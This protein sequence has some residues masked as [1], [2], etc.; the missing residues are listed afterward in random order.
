MTFLLTEDELWKVVQFKFKRAL[1]KEVKQANKE[2]VA[3]ST[4]S[5]T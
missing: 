2:M 5:N 4:R 3:W 1:L